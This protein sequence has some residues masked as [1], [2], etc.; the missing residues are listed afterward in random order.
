MEASGQLQAPAASP[1]RKKSPVYVVWAPEPF[2]T[3]W[4][5]KNALLMPGTEP[6]FLGLPAHCVIAVPTEISL[7]GHELLLLLMCLLQSPIYIL[8]VRSRRLVRICIAVSSC[9]AMQ[10]VMQRN[11][12]QQRWRGHGLFYL[13]IL[14]SPC[15]KRDS[16][17]VTVCC[18]AQGG[19]CCIHATL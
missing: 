14:L 5:E 4:E 16:G 6:L 13:S 10:P 19:Q 17:W 18:A 3:L 2:W 9:Y 15:P 12:R 8:R 7:L 11:S 1:P